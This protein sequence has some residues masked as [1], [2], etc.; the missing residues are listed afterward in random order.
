MWATGLTFAAATAYLRVAADKHYFTDVLASA[1]IGVA[2]GWAVPLGALSIGI[3]VSHQRNMYARLAY[4]MGETYEMQ[5]EARSRYQATGS[6]PT[7]EAELGQPLR[8]DY[9]DGGYYQF[10]KNGVIRI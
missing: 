1:A 7:T 6:W 9:P 10:E 2:V 4:A 5:Q 3:D 8:N